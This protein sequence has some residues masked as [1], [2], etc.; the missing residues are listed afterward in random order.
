MLL[1]RRQNAYE[2]DINKAIPGSDKQKDE[3]C[4]TGTWSMQGTSDARAWAAQPGPPGGPGRLFVQ[5][6]PISP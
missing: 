5:A 3:A 6:Q 1:G 4:D 2:N